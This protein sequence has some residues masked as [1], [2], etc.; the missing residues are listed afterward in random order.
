[1]MTIRP[2]PNTAATTHLTMRRRLTS[3]MQHLA[4]RTNPVMAI[5]LAAVAYLWVASTVLAHNGAIATAH[6]LTDIIIDG[7]L[8][9]WPADLPTYAAEL[10][11][12]GDKPSTDVDLSCSFRVGYGSDALY[13]AVEVT[14]QS[15][16]ID[17]NAGSAWDTQD[18]CSVYLDPTHRPD[19]GVVLQYFRRGDALKVYGFGAKPDDVEVAV[20]RIDT[21]WLYEW[22]IEMD[23]SFGSGGPVGFDIDVTDKD[24]DGSFTWMSWGKGSQKAYFPGRTGDLFPLPEGGQLQLGR[25]SGQV[26]WRGATVESQRLP[27]VSIQ[28]LTSRRLWSQVECDESGNYEARLPTGG[29]IVH[30]VDSVGSRIV[31]SDHVHVWIEPD[32]NVT[33]NPLV[34]RALK[35]PRLIGEKGVLHEESV[36]PDAIDR[37]VTAYLDYHKIPGISI[38]IVKDGE[39][40]YQKGVGVKNRLTGEPVEATTLF[41]A[42]S[43]TKPLFSF[44]V[45]RLV[46]RGILDLDTPL[47]KYLPYADI[48]SDERYKQITARMVLCHRTGFPNWR[49]GKLELHFEPGTK[50]QYSGEGFEYLNAVVSHLTEKPISQVMQEEVFG[51][52]GIENAHLTWGKGCDP[53]LVATP[54][55]E[56]NIVTS[57]STWDEPWMAG[58]LH[59][60]AGNYA[61]FLVGIVDEV[62]LSAASFS[63]MLRP[64]VEL[65]ES[66]SDQNFGLGI[67]VGQTA[68]G[69]TYGHGG[70][71]N[72]FTSGFEVYKEQGF[73]YVFL[74]N[75]HHAA[76]FQDDLRKFLVTGRSDDS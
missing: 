1:M 25:V 5:L 12:L 41:E 14:D 55:V 19:N 62:G 50:Q 32:G 52:L 61:K 11:D 23:T 34:V 35:N 31:E 51:P 47:Y 16:V 26:R 39:V 46:E 27:Q 43:M 58:C 22:R 8:G 71:N 20:R 7:E 2:L 3:L 33:A 30:P 72:G 73:G 69:P 44:A 29:Y 24:E 64:Q 75:N 56:H 45:C 67:V 60:D 63:E 68:F 74:V 59:I 18:G 76:A 53:T 4:G 15:H 21:G 37:F 66:S 40:I 57:K 17:E 38:A 6:P 54:H 65:P 13:V 42:A 70:R 9:D 28:S 10:A 48:E 49:N 36:N